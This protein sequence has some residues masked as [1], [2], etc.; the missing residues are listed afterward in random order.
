V[1]VPGEFPQRGD[2]YH[3]EFDRPVGAHYAVVV[4]ADA[5]NQNTDTVVLAVITSKQTQKIYPH[6]YLIPARLLPE[7]S[8]VKCHNLITWP[9]E[10]LNEE[11]YIGTLSAREVRGLDVALQKALDVWL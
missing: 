4:S 6:E 11:T 5:I 1:T 10:G 8:K 7:P 9:E 3:V 2:I